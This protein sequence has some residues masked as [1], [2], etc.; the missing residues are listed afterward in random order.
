M[1]SSLKIFLIPPLLTT[2]IAG[3]YKNCDEFNKEI[4]DWMPYKLQDKI[5]VTDLNKTDTLT[6][7]DSKINH[8]DK[9]KFFSMCM[10]MD[11][12][13]VSL[14]SDSIEIQAEFYDSGNANNSTIYI[15][16]E[17]L[18]YSEQLDNLVLNGHNYN[19]LQIYKGN[20][21]LNGGRFDKVIISKSIGI[22]AIIEKNRNWI[23]LDNNIRNI[24]F[25]NINYNI[26][27]CD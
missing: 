18:N 16:G 8:T 7:T 13:I 25:S 2:L 15:N 27:G 26:D 17:Y 19:D 3:C 1:K 14:S 20:T 5:M 10:C 12:F 22:I 21:A 24:F 23:I 4:L 6:V 9:I 11:F